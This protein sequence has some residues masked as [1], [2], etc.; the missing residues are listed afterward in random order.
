VSVSLTDRRRPLVEELR[1]TPDPWE[2]VQRF[3]DRPHLLFLDSAQEHPTLGRYSYVTA[4]PP[5][6]LTAKG[7]D[8]RLNGRPTDADP[9]ALLDDWLEQYRTESLPFVPPFQGG[10]D[11]LGG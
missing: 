8:V 10:E 7:D 11:G 2:V 3:A 6:W 5:L 1:P 9:L 4:D